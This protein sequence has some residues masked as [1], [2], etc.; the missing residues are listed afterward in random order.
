MAR[1]NTGKMGICDVSFIIARP[2]LRARARQRSSELFGHPRALFS[3]L[4]A[5]ALERF[6]FFG[7]QSMLALYFL[8]HL[9]KPETVDG[10]AGLTFL[11]S[12]LDAAGLIYTPQQ[13]GSVAFGV[14]GAVLSLSPLVGG[15]LSDKVLGQVAAIR[16]AG[17]LSALGC[18]L[19]ASE[20]FFLFGLFFLA[21][22]AGCF[23]AN[24]ASQISGLYA[25][26]DRRR[27]AAF[28]LFYMAINVGVIIAPVVCGGIG[29]LFGWSYGFALAGLGM[30][31]GCVVFVL[32]EPHLPP[33][34]LDVA[35]P[36]PIV[37][38]TSV[39]AAPR[40]L[41]LAIL[42]TSFSLILMGAQQIYNAYL[43]WVEG[44]A[45]LTVGAYRIPT[46]WLISLDTVCSLLALIALLRF[47]RRGIG[48]MDDLLGISL[49]GLV[50]ALS[51]MMLV[52]ASLTTSGPLGVDFRWL[53]AFH[54]LNGIG[55]AFVIPMGL[56]IYTRLAP[57]GFPA[58]ML[59]L[60][61]L[62]YAVANL[63]AGG[64]GGLPSKLEAV[65]FWALHAVIVATGAA[66]VS[67]LRPFLRRS[68]AV[69][70]GPRA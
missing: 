56:S 12:S 51:Y 37:G 60:F 7:V 3:L 35:P 24:I 65:D 42:A 55:F 52:G 40:L 9:L 4:V 59:G 31:A 43:V 21:F 58:S 66:A 44:A 16:W 18:F 19:I 5:E 70:D 49:G 10:V 29:A 50:V 8:N 47:S 27:E 20:V 2:E 63:L 11:I 33:R 34:R 48:R 57:P 14:Y 26:D 45:D 6:A 69:E 53:M 36:G 54:I 30:L 23:K 13:F 1:S 15:L 32:N 39:K 64:V 46:S 62:Q 68:L 41:A 25:C 67:F 61:Y 17:L 22:G 38:A 28:K